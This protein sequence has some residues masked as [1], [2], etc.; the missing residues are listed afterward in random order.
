MECMEYTTTEMMDR[1]G[2]HT[3]V[4]FSPAKPRPSQSQ[5]L[6]CSPPHVIQPRHYSQTQSL[7]MSPPLEVRRS[8]YRAPLVQ[9]SAH[10]L[11]QEMRDRGGGWRNERERDW[12]RERE[13]E[14]ERGWAQREWERERERGRLE[15]EGKRKGEEGNI[16][17]W[18][19]RVWS[20]RTFAF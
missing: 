2:Y 7:R 10:D 20:T 5:S 19:L 8:P 13:R 9:L 15:R 18:D 12:E 17:L 11:E 6:R 3:P 16:V 14:M 1:G 4:F